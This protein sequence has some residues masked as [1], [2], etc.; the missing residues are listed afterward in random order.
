MGRPDARGWAVAS[1]SDCAMVTRGVPAHFPA[2]RMAPTDRLTNLMTA[3]RRRPS[4]RMAVAFHAV[5]MLAVAT[6]CA[7]GNGAGGITAPVPYQATPAEQA[8]V[9]TLEQRTFS[10]FWETANPTNGLVPDRWPSKSFSS[11]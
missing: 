9:D 3:M 8:F 6:A 5:A 11:V 1:R 2:S 7:S 10:W 4:R